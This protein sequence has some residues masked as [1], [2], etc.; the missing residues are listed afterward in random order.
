MVSDYSDEPN[1]P[2]STGHPSTPQSGSSEI[3]PEFPLPQPSMAVSGQSGTPPS[4]EANLPCLSPGTE[5]SGGRYKIEKLVT[6]GDLGA[7]YRAIDTRFNRPCAVK[8]LLDEFQ[9]ETERNQAVEWFEREGA[10]LLDLNHPSVPRV[11]DFLIQD[12]KYYLVMDFIEGRTMAEILEKEGNVPGLHGARGV[13]EARARS[14]GQQI[15]SVLSYLHRQSPPIIF[16]DL[17]PSNIMI[18]ERDEDRFWDCSYVPGTG[19]INAYHDNWLRT[20]GAAARY[21][22]ATQRYLR[23]GS[24]PA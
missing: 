20:A 8:E 18:T 17:K 12:D 6:A 16:R 14:W 2:K 19:A 15:C 3:V 13:T 9:N 10:F 24:H 11:R 23:P 5:L 4:G 1:N 21:A 22:G 7:V